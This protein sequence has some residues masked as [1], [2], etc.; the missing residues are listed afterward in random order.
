MRLAMRKSFIGDE[1]TR[2]RVLLMISFLDYMEV[3]SCTV[4]AFG[5]RVKLQQVGWELGMFPDV[6]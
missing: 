5:E 4:V 3:Y 6:C 2:T 1:N